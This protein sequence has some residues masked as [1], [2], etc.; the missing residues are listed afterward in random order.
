VRVLLAGG[1]VEAAEPKRD[2]AAAFLGE[3]P[4]PEEF[5]DPESEVERMREELSKG[6]RLALRGNSFLVAVLAGPVLE[7]V[8]PSPAGAR[9]RSPETLGS[10]WYMF[11]ERRRSAAVGLECRIGPTAESRRPALATL[12]TDPAWLSVLVLE[13]VVRR[14]GGASSAIG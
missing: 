4:G 1:R 5:P 6:T 2:R 8:E 12:F 3:R 14:V 11:S 7:P 13:R 10:R 9:L